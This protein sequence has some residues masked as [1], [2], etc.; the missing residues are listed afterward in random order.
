MVAD[1][2]DYRW[3]AYGAATAG[4]RRAKQGLQKVVTG[5]QRGVEETLTASMALYRMRL[6][7]EGSEE[8]ETVDERALTRPLGSVSQGERGGVRGAENEV[9]ASFLREWILKKGIRV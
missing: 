4:R 8:R 6:H 2:D 5:L 1:P 3:S 9:F 7:N